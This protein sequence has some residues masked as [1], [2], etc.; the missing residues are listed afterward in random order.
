MSSVHALLE[1][2]SQKLRGKLLNRIHC[3]MALQVAA[4]PCEKLT[5]CKLRFVQ[6]DAKQIIKSLNEKYDSRLLRTIRTTIQTKTNILHTQVV[7]DSCQRVRL[8]SQISLCIF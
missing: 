6:L 1:K 7:Q 4:M 3:T 2:V 8:L 5:K